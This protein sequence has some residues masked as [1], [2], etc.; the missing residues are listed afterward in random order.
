MWGLISLVNA[1]FRLY[2]WIILAR[3]LLSWVRVDPWHPAVVWL[4]RLTE[5]VLR[6]FRRILPAVGGI[7]FSPIL[8]FF[9]LDIARQVLIGLLLQLARW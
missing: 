8:V 7:D 2:S 6:P 9:A 4:H 5:P 1:L 3:V